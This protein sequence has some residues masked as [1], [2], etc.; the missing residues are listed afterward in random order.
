MLK[1]IRLCNKLASRRNNKNKPIFGKNNGNSKVDGSDVGNNN[2]EY[3]KKSE[4][5]K[6]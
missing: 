5:S 2:M 6:S 4:K 3:A 1:K